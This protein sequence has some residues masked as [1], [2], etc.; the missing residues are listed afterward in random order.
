MFNSNHSTNSAPFFLLKRPAPLRSVYPTECSA[1]DPSGQFVA[2]SAGNTR[3]TA[4]K[5]HLNPYHVTYAAI[6][7]RDSEL[8]SM[9]SDALTT[10]DSSVFVLG[11]VLY[12][13]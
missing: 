13:I 9:S 12:L 1:L 8:Q 2:S 5:R 4:H 10:D 11:Y 7:T 6:S 3:T